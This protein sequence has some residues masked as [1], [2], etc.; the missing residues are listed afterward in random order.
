MSPNLGQ[1]LPSPHQNF[2]KVKT[3]PPWTYSFLL[4]YTV[5]DELWPGCVCPFRKNKAREKPNIEK[6]RAVGTQRGTSAAWSLSTT[7]RLK[8]VALPDDRC[9]SVSQAGRRSDAD[10][11]E[12]PVSH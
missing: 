12:T 9:N 1:V 8:C 3:L 11:D 10:T 7:V 6:R 4:K 2:L 5:T